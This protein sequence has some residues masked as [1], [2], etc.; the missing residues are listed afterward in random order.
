M[1]TD[2]PEI[3]ARAIHAFCDTVFG[4]LDGFAPIR[5]I[6]EKGTPGQKPFVEFLGAP[7]ETASLV[8][9]A[10]RASEQSRA[11][12]AVPAT[13]KSRG[14]AKEHDIWQTGVIVVDIDAG[15]IAAGHAHAARHLGQPSMVVASGGRTPD[16]QEKLHLYWRLTEAVEGDALVRVA[17]ARGDLARKLGGDPSFKR[18]TQPIRVAGSIHGKN[19]H[20]APVRLLKLSAQEYD[21]DEIC[22][23]IAAMPVLEGVT[24][25]EPGGHSEAA[26]RYSDLAAKRVR[27][28]GRD[29][30]TRYD[31]LS[32]VMGHWI[33]QVRLGHCSLEDARLA[34]AQHNAALIDPPWDES[35]I[36]REFHAL[37]KRDREANNWFAPEEARMRTIDPPRQSE[38]EIANTCIARHG[39]DF[40]FTAAWGAWRV[41]SGAC[42]EE[43]QVNAVGHAFRLVC[44]SHAASSSDAM[45]CK[46]ASERTVSAVLRLASRDPRVAMAP[47]DWDRHPMLLNTPTGVIDLQTGE[48]CAPDRSL[49]LT[50]C[51]SVSIGGSAPNW[52]RFIDDITC[53]DAELASYLQ[54]LAGYV[55]SGSTREQ[56]F[57][58]FHGSGANGKSVFLSVLG[59][60]LGT[61]A[62][63]AALDTFMA[64]NHGRH[65]TELAGLRA[66]RLVVVPE[67]DVGASWNEA[68]IKTVTG[69]ESIRANFM[70]QNHFEFLPQFKL[71]VAGNHKPT[72]GNS[73]EAMRR[74]LHLVPFNLAVPPDRRDKQLTDRLMAEAPGILAWMIDGC[75]DWNSRGLDPPYCV[76]N[77]SESYF[78]AED[79]VGQ[80]IA[81]CCCIAGG[82]QATSRDLF[83]SWKAWAEAHGTF[84]GSAKSLGE[85]LAQR[86]FIGGHVNRSR[87]WRG[88]SVGPMPKAAEMEQ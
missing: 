71:L 52:I 39:A 17:S 55:A 40:R 16:G 62:A 65:L 25:Q 35:R 33:R 77:A 6:A 86:G 34:V 44:R 46:I 38:D 30:T 19:S 63:T 13:V 49:H 53:G 69:G 29:G 27:S 61:Y 58:F 23:R 20:L 82:A 41:W 70:R 28:E 64:G 83:A 7:I 50:Q 59:K 5:L 81:E 47:D 45:A 21:L 48:W 10:R 73:G 43:D 42:W 37:L 3:D 57:A 9:L 85:A 12:Y 32:R 67:V 22:D 56:I 14:T 11:L 79:S 24:V 88:I 84:V 31:A 15:D 66:A 36:E 75:A 76:L 54:R 80:W 8:Q 78:D 68:R 26:P 18:M 87:G 2:R 1:P 51:T 4:Y 74:R 72:L 60:V